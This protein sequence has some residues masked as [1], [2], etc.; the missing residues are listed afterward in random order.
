MDDATPS[1]TPAAPPGGGTNRPAPPTRRYVFEEPLAPVWAR[2]VLG[3]TLGAGIGAAAPQHFA[4]MA[5]A[6][7]LAA[8]AAATVAEL[9]RHR[10]RWRLV[11]D[12]GHVAD[13]GPDAAP[14]APS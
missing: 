10:P 1:E 12:P 3:A 2:L 14:G 7:F 4:A 13:A 8:A 6:P 5:L 11:A 9:D